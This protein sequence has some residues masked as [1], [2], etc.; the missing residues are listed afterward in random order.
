MRKCYHYANVVPLEAPSCQ[1]KPRFRVL[2]KYLDHPPCLRCWSMKGEMRHFIISVDRMLDLCGRSRRVGVHSAGYVKWPFLTVMLS[3]GFC[4]PAGNHLLRSSDD[5]FGEARLDRISERRRAWVNG[6]D[7]L[8][9]EMSQ[10]SGS[11]TACN[12]RSPFFSME[13]NKM[14]ILSI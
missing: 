13:A 1:V 7:D 10:T 5:G 14:L 6:G 12:S 4:G 8:C 11:F 3:P 2:N 9:S